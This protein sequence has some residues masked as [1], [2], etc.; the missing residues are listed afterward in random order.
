MNSSPR[1]KLISVCDKEGK[2]VEF[3][4]PNH[5]G[6]TVTELLAKAHRMAA[7]IGGFVKTSS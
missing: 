1:I 3:F 5:I 2:T 6:R 7:E 4:A